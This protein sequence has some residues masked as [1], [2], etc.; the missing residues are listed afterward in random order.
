MIRDPWAGVR[1]FITG[2][3]GFKGAWLCLL[4][5]EMG[6]EV[7]GYALHPR[8]GSLF[9]RA[10]VGSRLQSDGRGDIRDRDE[11]RAAIDTARPDVVLHLAAQSIVIDAFDDPRETFDTNVMGTL[12][13][14]D[15]LRHRRHP[16]R[17]VVVTSDK[18]YQ[19]RDWCWGYRESD[20][21]GG[22][23]PYSASKAAA[24]H[25]AH[26]MAVSYQRR[27]LE[28]ATA[29]A[30]NVVGGGDNTPH[31]LVPEIISALA[32][33]RE[34]ALRSPMA[35][36]PW[37]HVLDPLAGYLSLASQLTDTV[38]HRAWNFGPASEDVLTVSDVARLLAH[39][40]GTQVRWKQATA[41]RHESQRLLIDSARA[42]HDLGWRP[43]LSSEEA[44]VWTAT[45]E[46]R[47]RRNRH[48]PY[49][50][51]LDQIT[52]FIDRRGYLLGAAEPTR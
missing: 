38:K 13:V 40:W 41:S 10:E 15:A 1:V 6:A 25:V 22:D 33:G 36:R 47:V 48:D 4:L 27:G 35:V 19:N 52:E 44:I 12:E 14:L 5:M 28:I 31:A 45:W 18:V 16:V 11:L 34:P 32:E 49:S 46:S 43:V 17:C 3:T 51:T 24:E 9:E 7:H 37:Q 50:V 2:H 29:R 26:A 20:P 8:R 23:D 39:E 21:L 42:R 30:G